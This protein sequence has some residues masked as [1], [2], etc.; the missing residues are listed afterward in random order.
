MRSSAW[1]TSASTS[2]SGQSG[3]GTVVQLF[4][5]NRTFAQRWTAVGDHNLTSSASASTCR[6]RH[7]QRQPRADLDLQRHGGAD[8]VLL[9]GGGLLNPQSGRCLD[10]PAANPTDGTA[11]QLYDCNGTAAQKWNLPS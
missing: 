6:G 2:R 3:N 4:A 5:C 10:V 1:P 9:A 11:L 7:G 8:L